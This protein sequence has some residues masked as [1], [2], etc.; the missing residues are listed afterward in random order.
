MGKK[1][2][3]IHTAEGSLNADLLRIFLEAH[4]VQVLVSQESAGAAYGL[5]I[6]R[7]GIARFYV[8]ADQE[9]A[10]KALLAALERGEFSLP[11]DESLP[12]EKDEDNQMEE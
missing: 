12:A 6:G 2:V 4:G 8:P 10:A 5:T 3:H 11:D 9:P 1:L 7:L